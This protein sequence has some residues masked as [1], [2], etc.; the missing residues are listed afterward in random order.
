MPFLSSVS[1]INKSIFYFNHQQEQNLMARILITTFFFFAFLKFVSLT[2][3]FS[4]T[5]EDTIFPCVFLYGY[6]NKHLFL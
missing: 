4:I 1:K 3:V 5:L 2:T 6:V